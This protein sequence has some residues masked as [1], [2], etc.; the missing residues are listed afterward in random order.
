MILARSPDPARAAFQPG[1]GVRLF[2]RIL[3]LLLTI[4]LVSGAATLPSFPGTPVSDIRAGDRDMP[5]RVAAWGAGEVV[6]VPRLWSGDPTAPLQDRSGPDLEL[7]PDSSAPAA[8]AFAIDR[9]KAQRCRSV[10]GAPPSAYRAQAPPT[11]S[12]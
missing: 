5:Y 3:V 1:E 8:F 2:H 11:V 10:A 9:L 6:T 7:S 12:A 4:A